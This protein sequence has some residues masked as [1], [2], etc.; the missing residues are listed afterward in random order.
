VR[1][2]AGGIFP[3]EGGVRDEPAGSL[4]LNV[5]DVHAG[6]PVTGGCEAPGNRKAAAAADIED[7]PAIG[8]MGLE[9]SQPRAVL[10]R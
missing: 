6:Y 1:S 10:L 4:D 8:K 5:A 9:V 7:I 3:D 2:A